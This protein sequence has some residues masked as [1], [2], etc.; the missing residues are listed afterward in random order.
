MNN[1]TKRFEKLRDRERAQPFGVLTKEEQQMLEVARP[2]NCLWYNGAWL[3]QGSKRFRIPT[4][5]ILN[6]E[7]KL[8]PEYEEWEI[9]TNSEGN[10]AAF[11]RA[12]GAERSLAMCEHQPNFVCFHDPFGAETTN[13]GDIPTW[14]RTLA[15]QVGEI[16]VYARFIK[17]T[18]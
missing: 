14:L 15:T 7:Y 13:A 1:I 9:R 18:Q 4:A 3:P 12:G 5:S 6:P 10:L 17:V 16:K 11:N 2:E 8:K